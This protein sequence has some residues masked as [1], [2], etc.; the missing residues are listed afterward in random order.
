M[1]FVDHE[2]GTSAWLEWRKGGLGASDAL[3][4]SD[5]VPPWRDRTR[6]YEL[7][8]RKTGR[9]A[10]QETSF[11]M[12][13]GQ[14]LEPIARRLYEEKTGRQARPCCVQ[15][16]RLDWLR[17]SLDGLDDWGEVIVEIKAPNLDSHRE[18][19]EGRVPD[20]YVPQ[21]L[22]QAAVTGI[23]RID[24]VSFSENKEVAE[25]DRLAVV[26][27]VADPVAMLKL[28]ELES[29][30]WAR[31]LFDYWPVAE[32]APATPTLALQEVRL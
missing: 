12:R 21:L 5:V 4:L 1:E 22:H 30:F 24:Y 19:L 6:P 16:S 15:H 13:R 32:A 26:R 3:I 25:G 18:A 23:S 8:Q 9:I 14:R 10:E 11:A 28:L 7:W 27:F 2:Q 29:V 31:V 20:Y 17:A